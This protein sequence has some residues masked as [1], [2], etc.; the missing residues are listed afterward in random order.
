MA[1][2]SEDPVLGALEH[3]WDGAYEFGIGM[4]GYWARRRD[5]LGGTLI[6]EDPGELQR[7]VSEDHAVHPPRGRGAVPGGKGP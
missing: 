5:G 3:A 7:M 1:K 6:D 4:D 2:S